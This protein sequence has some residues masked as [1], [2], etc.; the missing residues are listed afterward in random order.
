MDG[1]KEGVT[2]SRGLCQGEFKMHVEV[3]TEYGDDMRSDFVIKVGDG[4]HTLDAEQQTCRCFPEPRWRRILRLKT[5]KV[6][7]RFIPVSNP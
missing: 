5:A 3:F 2:K 7:G 1:N 4:W 6:I